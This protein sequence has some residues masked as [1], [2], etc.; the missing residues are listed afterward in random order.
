[1]EE[2]SIG[3]VMVRLHRLERDNRR[4]KRIGVVIGAVLAAVAMMGQSQP[5]S[6]IT[7]TRL[8]LIDATGTVRATLAVGYPTNANGSGPDLSKGTPSLTF[9]NRDSSRSVIL[10]F[11]SDTEFPHLTLQS[12]GGAVMLGAG[13]QGASLSVSSNDQL[14]GTFISSLGDGPGKISLTDSSH[15]TVWQAP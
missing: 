4:L 3:D 5:P 14:T 9:Y 1:M 12:S 13:S 15:N 6:A 10:D 7:T 11:N 2:S 8:D